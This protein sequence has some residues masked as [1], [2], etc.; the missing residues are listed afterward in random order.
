MNTKPRISVLIASYC[1]PELLPTI[2]HCLERAKDP[3][4]IAIGV[5]H[6]DV[7]PIENPPSNIRYLF[8]PF[9]ES[10][11]AG[12]AR[13]VTN[14]FY[15]GEE[16]V[17]QIDS[18]TRFAPNW[19]EVLIAM[20]NSLNDEKAVLTGYPPEYS[21]DLPEEKWG[22]AP[23]ASNVYSFKDGITHAKPIPFDQLDRPRR[24]VHVSAGF[25]FCPGSVIPSV[26]YDRNIYFLGEEMN[27]TLRLYTHGY[28]LY[29]P[30]K[31]V[32]YHYY[33]RPLH[34]RHWDHNEQWMAYNEQSKIRLAGV[35]NNDPSIPK[36][37]RLG[38]ART[39][40][41][42]KNY[43]GIDCARKIIHLDTI[44]G[45]EPPIKNDPVKWSYTKRTFSRRMTIPYDSIDMCK[46]PRFWALIFKDKD[47]NEVYRLDIEYKNKEHKKIIDGISEEILLEF[48]YFWPAQTPETFIIWP[49]SETKQWLHPTKIKISS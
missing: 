33:I 30:N 14:C 8:F 26:P 25:M 45:A 3:T 31:V 1:D 9:A 32:L 34:E 10:K 17:L 28:N 40:E 38:T 24:A 20:W 41:D 21:P 11:G 23:L 12:W 43:A 16:F 37:Y 35:L 29:H 15:R 2:N 39:L 19:D 18:H 4:R 13:A 22:Y 46:D 7:N 44:A 48:D 27:M 47:D 36:A 42:F 5:C 6:Q 49:Y